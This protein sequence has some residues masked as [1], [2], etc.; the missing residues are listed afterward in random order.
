MANFGELKAQ[1]ASDL[2]RSN[3]TSEIATAVLDAIRDHD[4]ERFWFNET[5]TYSL[6]TVAGTDTYTLAAQAPIQEFIKIDRVKVQ[7]GNTWYDLDEETWDEMDQLYATP[8]FGQPFRWAFQG[9]DQFRIYPT[10]Q[11]VYSLQI[12]G[13]YRMVPLVNDGDTNDWT[14]RAQNLIRYTALKRLFAYPIRDMQQQQ[15]ADASGM[16]ELEYLRRETERRARSGE[17]APYYG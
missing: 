1:I 9:A 4:T 13:H 6:S 16:R 11:A 5:A 2:R 3:L 10:P 15:S 12:F 8:T 14:S 7:V 17:M